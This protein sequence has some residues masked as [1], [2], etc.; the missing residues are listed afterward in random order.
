MDILIVVISW[1][2]FLG[3]PLLIRYVFFKKKL[4]WWMSA[5]IATTNAAFWL[6]VEYYLLIPLA[7]EGAMVGIADRAAFNRAPYVFLIA[8]SILN[9]TYTIFT[10]PKRQRAESNNPK[11]IQVEKKASAPIKHKPSNLVS[12]KVVTIATAAIILAVGGHYYLSS[13]IPTQTRLTCF[14]DSQKLEGTESAYLYCLR[15]HGLVEGEASVVQANDGESEIK[16]KV[17]DAISDL[18]RRIHLLERDGCAE[19]Q[20]GSRDLEGNFIGC[21]DTAGQPRDN[22]KDGIR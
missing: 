21:I 17:S 20:H 4:N 19:G 7:H 13:Y 1:F 22:Y 9:D 2:L 5:L 15:Q 8:F 16:S 10:N 11:A 14:K 18:D 12:S 6:G 3:A